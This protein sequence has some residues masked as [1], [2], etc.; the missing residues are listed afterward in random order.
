MVS[1]RTLTRSPTSRGHARSG[2]HHHRAL[3]SRPRVRPSRPRNRRA[4]S[5]RA[6]RGRT[7]PRLVERLADLLA[8]GTARAFGLAL[9]KGALVPGADADLVVWD[10]ERTWTIGAESPFAGLEVT[11]DACLILL[12]GHAVG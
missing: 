4:R 3:R 7:S 11:G 12:H 9:R 10:P 5:A 1:I 6:Q 2:R 8:G